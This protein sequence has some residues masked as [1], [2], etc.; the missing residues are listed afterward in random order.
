[1]INCTSFV[2]PVLVPIIVYNLNPFSVLSL[3]PVT[4]QL[5]HGCHLP[6]CNILY[7]LG[8]QILAFKVVSSTIP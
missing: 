5:L 3:Y 1:M 4:I 8:A 6:Y 2:A 7:N